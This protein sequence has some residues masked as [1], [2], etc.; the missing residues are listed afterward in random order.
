MPTSSSSRM[1]MAMCCSA[2]RPRRSN[3]AWS[4]RTRCS[5]LSGCTRPSADCEP[6]CSAT[7]GVA[8]QVARV[9][10]VDDLLLVELVDH[11]APHVELHEA[12]P[13]GVGGELVAVLVGLEPDDAGLQAQRQVLGDDDD[14]AALAAEAAARR[15][16]CGGRWRRRRERLRAA[17]SSSWWLSST[18][19]VPPS[20]LTGIGSMQRAVPGAELLEEAQARRAAQP[21]SGWWRLPSSSVSTTS[22]S[23]TSCSANRVTASGSASSTEVSTT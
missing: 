13:A 23:T 15:R 6:E 22:G 21:S 9:V 5:R 7:P 20:S 14:L 4:V 12:G 11:R 18:R 1:S 2:E 3:I 10:E 19:S 8:R 16:G 17:P